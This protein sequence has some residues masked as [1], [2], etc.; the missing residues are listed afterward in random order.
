MT[1]CQATELRPPGE[2]LWTWEVLNV[3]HQPPL[4]RDRFRWRSVRRESLSKSNNALETR[5]EDELFRP[6]L[7][8]RFLNFPIMCYMVLGFLLIADMLEEA[9]G[10]SHT[11]IVVRD[12]EF[13]KRFDGTPGDKPSLYDLVHHMI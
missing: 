1:G 8:V 5:V 7:T 2:A 6:L 11:I 3:V 13:Q 4:E 9:I 10:L 12:G